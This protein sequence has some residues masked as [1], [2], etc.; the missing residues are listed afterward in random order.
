[1][2]EDEIVRIK[3]SIEQAYKAIKH[4]PTEVNGTTRQAFIREKTRRIREDHKRLAALLGEQEATSIVIEINL[5]TDAAD[6]QDLVRQRQP[7]N[8]QQ[9]RRARG[10]TARQIAEEAGVPFG[11]EYQLEIGAAVSRRDAIDIV[12]ALSELTGHYYRLEDFALCLKEEV[13]AYTKTFPYS[14]I[15]RQ[16]EEG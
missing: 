6:Q 3:A 8:F 9:V 5:A 16:Q 4:A 2:A 1:M 14:P 13:I 11:T 10:L 15:R 7:L 12:H